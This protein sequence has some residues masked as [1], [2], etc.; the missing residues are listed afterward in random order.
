MTWK[1]AKWRVARGRSP[2]ETPAIGWGQHSA[3]F[4]E[5]GTGHFAYLAEAISPCPARPPRPAGRA[6]AGPLAGG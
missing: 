3:R 5:G 4:T 1:T 6:A 2:D